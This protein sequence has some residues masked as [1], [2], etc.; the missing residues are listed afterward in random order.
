VAENRP[1]LAGFFDEEEMNALQAY[2]MDKGE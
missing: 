1:D 2:L